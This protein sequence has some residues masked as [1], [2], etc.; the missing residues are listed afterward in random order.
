M[1]YTKG[2]LVH[3]EEK[4]QPKR[5]KGEQEGDGCMALAWSCGRRLLVPKLSS[6]VS[7]VER[8]WVVSAGQGILD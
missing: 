2:E 1:Y 6:K 7:L 3:L 8:A 4:R 5:E